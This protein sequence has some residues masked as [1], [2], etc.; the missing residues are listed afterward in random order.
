M[1]HRNTWS[2]S[3]LLSSMSGRSERRPLVTTTRPPT[4]RRTSSMSAGASPATEVGTIGPVHVGRFGIP[5]GEMGSH[6]P[7]SGNAVTFMGLSDAVID[8][9]DG[10][11]DF[12]DH[13][14]NT[15][16]R[17]LGPERSRDGA[18]FP[19]SSLSSTRSGV[20]LARI[21]RFQR[22]S[23]GRGDAVLRHSWSPRASRARPGCRT[24]TPRRHHRRDRRRSRRV[25]SFAMKTNGV[26]L[27]TSSIDFAAIGNR[28]ELA[29]ALDLLPGISVTEFVGQWRHAHHHPRS[30]G[31]HTFSD[32][33]LADLTPNP[34]TATLR[35]AASGEALNGQVAAAEAF[36]LE[37]ERNAA[38][39][40][41]ASTSVRSIRP[42][43]S[44]PRSTRSTASRRS[45]ATR[46]SRS[47]PTC[48]D[49]AM[50]SAGLR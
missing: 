39:S 6:D 49:P 50:R 8:V 9:I 44:P 34:A 29:A 4:S 11:L 19:I 48:S 18:T 36:A 7:L 14:G 35:R 47:L 3:W 23:A 46:S 25:D 27:D 15:E 37:P 21:A 30:D 40:S 5:P 12:L 24:S 10:F 2:P 32:I 13:N 41:P 16:T 26:P 38:R 17:T 43:S 1:Q 45:S 28:A 20:R 31:P 42:R 33:S 22:Q